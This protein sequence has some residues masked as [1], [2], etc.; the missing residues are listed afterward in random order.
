MDEIISFPNLSS[1]IPLDLWLLI[2]AG[3]EVN[4]G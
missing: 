4:P 2:H 3:M 1:H